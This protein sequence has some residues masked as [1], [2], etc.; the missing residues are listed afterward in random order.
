MWP[1]LALNIPNTAQV[2]PGSVT[3]AQTLLGRGRCRPNNVAYSDSSS[4]QQFT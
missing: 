1:P 3:P 2:V 4:Y